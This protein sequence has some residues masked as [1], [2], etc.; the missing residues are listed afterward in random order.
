[1]AEVLKSA[2]LDISAEYK[3]GFEGMID[4][5]VTLDGLLQAREDLIREI[6]STRPDLFLAIS[7][8]HRTEIPRA[9]GRHKRS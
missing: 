8:L 4:K 3:H 2:Q 6:K 1:M 7:D 5:P 9:L